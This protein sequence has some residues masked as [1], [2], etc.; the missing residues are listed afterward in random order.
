MMKIIETL[1]KAVLRGLYTNVGVALAL[2]F[3]FMYFYLACKSGGCKSAIKK[4]IDAFTT[5][6]KFRKVF[7]FAFYSF[8]L[9]SRTILA[10]DFW[11]NPAISNV[12]GIWGIYDADGKL[13]TENI[14]NLLLFIPFTFLLFWVREA[15]TNNKAFWWKYMAWGGF[16][17][18]CLSGS[19]E[20]LQLFLKLG[21]FQL[22]DL[23]F[24]TIGGVVGGLGYGLFAI[25]RRFSRRMR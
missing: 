3:F 17:G 11:T 22:S 6:K 4:W 12:I 8:M 23:F 9:L 13:Y 24:N 15:T 10:R 21:E 2:T 18:F 14:E 5:D 7:A 1:I 16:I 25:I 19:I 20:F